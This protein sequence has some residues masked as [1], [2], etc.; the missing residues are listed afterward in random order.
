MSRWLSLVAGAAVAAT[1]VSGCNNPTCGPGTK[2]MQVS[3]GS[4]QCQPVDIPS[5]G[6]ACDADAG[7]V[8]VG[9]KCVG[10]ITCGADSVLMNGQCIGTGGG[11]GDG[12]VTDPPPCAKPATGR[13]CVNGL[14]RDFASNAV[15]TQPIHVALYNPLTYI[16]HGAAI[17]HTD[18]PAGAGGYVFQDVIP[19]GLGLIAVVAGDA[20]LEMPNAAGAT[21]IS[22]A[23]GAQNVSA[24][25][26]YRVDI[27]ALT[28]VT[29]TG[30]G[31]TAP[32]GTDWYTSGG[33][34]AKFYSDTK[35]D[36]TN[37]AATEMNPVSGVS[38]STPSGS[39]NPVDTSSVYFGADLNTIAVG[40]TSTS[41]IGA[42]ITP[43][44]AGNITTFSGSGGV[45]GSGNP[46]TWETQSGGSAAHIIFI[47]RF[48]PN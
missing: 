25:N 29:L 8:I 5:Q 39:T 15:F 3:G 20:D 40:A 47:S 43:P 16:Q 12:G 44:P 19:P 38:V 14:V 37:L 35:P 21:Y 26:I 48:H 23:S 34:I 31:N 42:A 4:I 22:A 33:Y 13:I 36:P 30:W 45:D 27:Y 10:A 7:A 18:V 6:I 41:A 32:G 2:Q 46:I 1:F 17:A 24:G 28:R 11:G 9:D